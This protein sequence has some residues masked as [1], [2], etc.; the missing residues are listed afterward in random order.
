MATAP[1]EELHRNFG[2]LLR[3]RRERN[4]LS[5]ESLAKLAEISRTSVVNIERG[6]Q[7][8]SL[9]TLYRLS[10]ALNCSPAVLLP[11]SGPA[12]SVEVRIGQASEEEV[13]LLSVIK[14]RMN[15]DPRS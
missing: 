13:H 1:D 3:E 4:G 14:Q 9:G 6:R 10:G 2:L 7:G 15:K 8:V 5:Q 11:G 12:E